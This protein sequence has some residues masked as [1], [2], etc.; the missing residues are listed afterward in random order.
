MK[1][2]RRFQDYLK[3]Q[4][5][6]PVFR[7]AYEEE[8]VYADLAVQIARLRVRKRLSQKHLARLLH[9]SQQTVSRLEDPRNASYSV[10]TLVK[11]AHALGKELKV[12]FI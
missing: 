5:K 2:A 4:L 9:T 11:V 12:K 8:G 6:N 3:D 7:K 1:G 10:R